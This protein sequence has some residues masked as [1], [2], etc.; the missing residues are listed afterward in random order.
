MKRFKAPAGVQVVM[1]ENRREQKKVHEFS[2]GNAML[3]SLGLIFIILVTQFNSFGKPFIILTEIALSVIG[4]LLGYDCWTIS[5]I[6]A[7]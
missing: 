3:I 2:F 6:M 5:T 4:F 7:E 1:T